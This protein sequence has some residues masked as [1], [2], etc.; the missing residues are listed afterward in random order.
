MIFVALVIVFIVMSI[1][2]VIRK[3]T[4]KVIEKK[5]MKVYFAFYMFLSLGL[6]VLNSS[7]IIETVNIM[8]FS[9]RFVFLGILLYKI[10]TND[11]IYKKWTVSWIALNIMSFLTDLVQYEEYGVYENM[12]DLGLVMVFQ[13]TI[14]MGVLFKLRH[15]FGKKIA[16]FNL[17]LLGVTI[18]IFLIMPPSDLDTI[19]SGAVISAVVFAIPVWFCWKIYLKTY[20]PKTQSDVEEVEECEKVVESEFQ[21]IT[22]EKTT[23]KSKVMEPEIHNARMSKISRL[24]KLLKLQNYIDIAKVRRIPLLT[25][26]TII[27]IGSLLRGLLVFNLTESGQFAENMKLISA[28]M[29]SII[30]ITAEKIIQAAIFMGLLMVMKKRE[31]TNIN[32]LINIIAISSLPRVIS[33]IIGILIG[34]LFFGFRFDLVYNL[35]NHTLLQTLYSAIYSLIIVIGA[36]W[37]FGLLAYFNSKL[38]EESYLKTIAITTLAIFGAFYMRYTF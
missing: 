16:K 13:L 1:V 26:I 37:S 17:A 27:I 32:E 24:K 34:C 19:V 18:V 30:P 7:T 38:I 33:G 3:L 5:W 20:F 12:L 8:T 28:L 11:Q 23:I 15:E 22:L 6:S 36:V 35:E 14:L 25:S 10:I 2:L 21:K 4:S 9:M 31:K 29:T